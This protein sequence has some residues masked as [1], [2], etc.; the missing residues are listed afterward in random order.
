[1]RYCGKCGTPVEYGRFCH[2]CGAP[3]DQGSYR[4]TAAPAPDKNY[5]SPA[6]S[7]PNKNL[8]I[9]LA[10]IVGGMIA[11][12]VLIVF[13]K[14]PHLVNEECDWC[15]HKPSVAYKNS[16]G[17]MAYVCRD[18]SKYCMFCDERAT[19]HYENLAGMMVFVCADC[20]EEMVE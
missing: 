17:E 16:E 7:A 1:M 15:Y 12:A 9:M 8:I 11:M 19:K 4:S 10:G 6:A 13:L 2:K 20:Y 14:M 5:R 3:V 18:C